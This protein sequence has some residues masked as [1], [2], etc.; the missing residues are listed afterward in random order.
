MLDQVKGL[1]KEAE[2]QRDRSLAKD[3]KVQVGD[4]EIPVRQ[5]TLQ[6]VDWATKFGDVEI[7]FVPAP[8]AGGVWAV[9]RSVLEV[10]ISKK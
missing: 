6:I 1:Q 10:F 4:H 7:Q 9:A 3:W 2:I 8:S 5:T